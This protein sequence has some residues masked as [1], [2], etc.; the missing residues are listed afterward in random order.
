MEDEGVERALGV[1][2]KE[3]SSLNEAMQSPQWC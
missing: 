3:E 1:E 2:L